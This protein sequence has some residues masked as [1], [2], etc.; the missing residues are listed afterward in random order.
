VAVLLVFVDLDATLALLLAAD[1]RLLALVLALELLDRAL[2]GWRW[3]LLLRAKLVDVPLGVIFRVHFI[4]NF[5]ANFLPFN[6]GNDVTRVVSLAKYS[7]G[8][9]E[10]L[11][12]V[13][14][15]RVIGFVALLLPVILVVAGGFILQVSVIGPGLAWTLLA[16]LA[17]LG[18]S[19]LVFWKGGLFDGAVLLLQTRTRWRWIHRIAEVYEACVSYRAHGRTMG[20]VF[21]ILQISVTLGILTTYLTAV[22]LGMNVALIYFV[23]LVPIISFLSSLPISANGIGVAEGGFVFFFGQVGA[24]A[25]EA[26]TLALV[27]RVM[28]IVAT[29]PGAVLLAVQGWPVRPEAAATSPG[30]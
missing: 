22:S 26:L 21:A 28:M 10:P 29:L 17:M 6:V 25:S 15:D 19:G 30:P 20:A 12:S 4:S 18:V 7:G 1:W 11:S 2:H 16:V 24:S 9:I 23:M 13:I 8:T 27:M 5:L 14:L 3:L